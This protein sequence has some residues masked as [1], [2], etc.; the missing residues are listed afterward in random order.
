MLGSHHASFDV[1]KSASLTERASISS[2]L[3]KNRIKGENRRCSPT[4]FWQ[5]TENNV[6]FENSEQG[7]IKLSSTLFI[8]ILHIFYE[9]C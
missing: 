7:L 8:L 4:G 6:K 5:D 9:L 2:H 3:I 1:V